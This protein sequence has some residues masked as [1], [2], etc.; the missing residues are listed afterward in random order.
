MIEKLELPYTSDDRRSGYSGPSHVQVLNKIN[1]I[2][3]H[4]QKDEVEN[5]KPYPNPKE[6]LDGADLNQDVHQLIGYCI[7]LGWTDKVMPSQHA[8]E[9]A[10]AFLKK[11]RPNPD[12]E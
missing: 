9:L 2:I 4:I 10:E 12:K 1:E 8:S 3:D 11:Y 6:I 5:K 7:S